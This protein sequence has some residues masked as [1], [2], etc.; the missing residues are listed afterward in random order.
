MTVNSGGGGQV[1]DPMQHE[2]KATRVI[3]TYE[4]QSKAPSGLPVT[5]SGPPE[6]SGRKR[7]KIPVSCCHSES[8]YL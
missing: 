1:A 4:D 6:L 7:S 2:D 5:H 8:S 3:R